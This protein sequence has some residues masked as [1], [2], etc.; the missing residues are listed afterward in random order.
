MSFPRQWQSSFRST[1]QSLVC[2]L[3]NS[4]LY[5]LPEESGLKYSETAQSFPWEGQLTTLFGQKRDKGRRC[6]CDALDIKIDLWTCWSWYWYWFPFLL[7]T[8]FRFQSDTCQTSKYWV[9]Q[10][11]QESLKCL[12]EDFR[13]SFLEQS[14]FYLLLVSLPSVSYSFA[15]Y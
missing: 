6:S 9:S 11:L 12:L 7:L 15:N 10:N 4:F 1:G 8:L 13:V 3:P 14:S 5:S 2:Q